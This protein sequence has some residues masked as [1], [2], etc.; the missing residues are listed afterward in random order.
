[1]EGGCPRDV[2]PV[3]I[4]VMEW[5][6]GRCGLCGDLDVGTSVG[7]GGSLGSGSDECTLFLYA[8]FFSH[9]MFL[10]YILSF[11]AVQV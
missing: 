6:A 1:M 10:L 11:F 3:D 9:H 5:A 4:G 8:I 2:G 7:A